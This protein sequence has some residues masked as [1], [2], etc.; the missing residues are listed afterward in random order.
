[1][2]KYK[3]INESSWV[4]IP[5][6]VVTPEELDI[7]NNGTKKKIEALKKDIIDRSAPIEI[8]V[9]ELVDVLAIYDKYKPEIKEGDVYELISFDMVVRR[10]KIMGAY[11]YKINNNIRNVILR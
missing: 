2:K 7:L 5:E 3:A 10:E 4:E 8:P 6:V 9:E 11:N 1:M